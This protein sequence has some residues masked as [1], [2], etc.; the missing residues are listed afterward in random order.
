MT[1][2]LTL[3]ATPVPRCMVPVSRWRGQSRR[4]GLPP[5]GQPFEG[6]EHLADPLHVIG[7]A[8]LRAQAKRAGRGGET[9]AEL[10]GEAAFLFRR[11]CPPCR[12]LDDDALLF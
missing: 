11:G 2:P 4:C 7:E 9:A 1:S 3:A 8:A 5:T 10:R 12:G 6:E